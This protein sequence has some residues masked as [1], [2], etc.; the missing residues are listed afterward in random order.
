M[1]IRRDYRGGVV[2]F[3]YSSIPLTVV[4]RRYTRLCETGATV[5]IRL[6]ILPSFHMEIMARR[7]LENNEIKNT[8]VGTVS[9]RIFLFSYHFFF[10]LKFACMYENFA[11]LN[12][13]YYYRGSFWFFQLLSIEN[14]TWMN[15]CIWYILLLTQIIFSG[16]F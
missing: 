9:Q 14:F 4:T 8:R 6:S 7:A 1:Y 11:D 3:H 15:F 12:W 10:F 16:K 5:S 2:R 13:R